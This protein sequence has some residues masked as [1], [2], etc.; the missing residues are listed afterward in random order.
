[1]HLDDLLQEIA[2]EEALPLHLKTPIGLLSYYHVPM[3]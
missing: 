1:M 2:T 3:W